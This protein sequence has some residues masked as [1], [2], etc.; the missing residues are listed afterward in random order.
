MAR[1]LK[2]ITETSYNFE[3]NESEDKKRLYISGVFSSAEKK[4][5]NGR[6]YP[7]TTLEREIKK[8][9]EGPISNNTCI[10]T[11]GHPQDDPET[12]LERSALITENLEWK[13]DDVYGK[14][15]VLNTPSGE[16]LASLIKDGVT[17]GISSR[18]LGSVNEDGTVNEDFTLLA[19]DVVANPSNNGSWVNGIYEGK[20]FTIPDSNIERPTEEEIQ[21]FLKEHE[22]KVWAVLKS[23]RGE[24]E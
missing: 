2:L 17:V 18:G 10:G 4:N 19:Y 20:T 23:F 13:N 22:K 15:R 9:K 5:K 12:P 14:A 8:L 21:E 16:I 3:I 1:E 6:I 11:I 7:R 24:D